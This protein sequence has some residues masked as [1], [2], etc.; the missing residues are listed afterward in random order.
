LYPVSEDFLLII[1]LFAGMVLNPSEV[2]IV[3]SGVLAL[4][5]LCPV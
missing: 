2:S 1:A 3:Y 4:K 5:E